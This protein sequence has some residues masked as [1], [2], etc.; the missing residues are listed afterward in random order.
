M[1]ELLPTKASFRPG[2]PIVVEVR[3]TTEPGPLTV[4]HLGT[5]VV[6]YAYR[7]GP[8]VTLPGLPAGGYAIELGELRTAVEV[9]ADAPI[10][11]SFDPLAQRAEIHC[12]QAG[13][14][15]VTIR[16]QPQSAARRQ[17]DASLGASRP[18]LDGKQPR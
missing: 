16:A 7:G 1:T 18:N 4:W 5:P 15:R 2:E 14:V 10:R 6:T 13:P 9:S 11:W 12:A 17:V 3:G 8:F